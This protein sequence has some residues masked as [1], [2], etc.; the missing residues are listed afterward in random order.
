VLLTAIGSG[1]DGFVS[2]RP[3]GCYAGS[4]SVESRLSISSGSRYEPMTLVARK[5]MQ[6]KAMQEPAGFTSLL[7]R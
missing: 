6:E 1:D 7:A 5:A 2:Y 4:N 3:E